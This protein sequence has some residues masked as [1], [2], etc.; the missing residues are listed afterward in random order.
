MITLLPND[1]DYL[2]Y[3]DLILFA[4]R[5][6]GEE[7]WLEFKENNLDPERIGQY[8]SALSNSAAS[9]GKNAGYLIWGIRDEDC[10]LIGT[11][12][13]PN[14]AKK[15]GEPLES[16]LSH[17]LSPAIDFTFY[18]LEIDGFKVVILRC[19][20]PRIAP[21]SFSN[22]EWIRVG[23]N[24]KKL[25]DFPEQE[26]K[27]WTNISSSSFELESCLYLSR[28]EDILQYLDVSRYYELIHRPYPSDIG[29][30]ISE[31]LSNHIVKKEDNESY[32]IT[33]LGMLC[34][35]KDLT[36]LVALAKKSI[37]VIVHG[38]D[39]L[40]DFQQEREFNSGYLLC[41]DDIISFVDSMAGS[42]MKIGKGQRQ[43]IH[44]F[45]PLII[46]EALSNAM[47]HQ[48]FS[49]QGSGIVIHVLSSRLIVESPGSFNED[50][51][52]FIDMASES[53]N[54]MLT[55]V[56]RKLGYAEEQ[57]SGFDRIEGECAKNHLPS[58]EFSL[59]S[60]H[61]KL[62]VIHPAG[63][64]QTWPRESILWTIYCY[65]CYRYVSGMVT[66][67]ANVRERLDIAESSSA[68]ASRILSACV[69]A[70]YLKKTIGGSS[71]DSSYVPY[72]A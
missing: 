25:K 36:Q 66:S 53:R 69:D 52:R 40:T 4:L 12:F 72:W 11:S 10:S 38:S 18:G 5:N 21:T 35:G 27:I 60:H 50:K 62:I 57:G 6:E 71:R 61:T 24:L 13:N 19:G 1:K 43:E 70:G 30:I 65:A 56:F 31:L 42:S 8:I 41:F 39:Y 33:N 20:T 16:Y 45:P 14:Q 58:I 15:G 63:K 28:V 37:R 46:H 2:F 44:R 54:R 68:T 9:Y 47:I 7:E 67:N 26:R 64:Y 23:N 34:F 29:N 3:K 48:D 55:R 59:S 17:L 22:V 49:L 51:M 32:S